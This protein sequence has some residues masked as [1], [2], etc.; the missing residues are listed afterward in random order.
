MMNRSALDALK[1]L[2]DYEKEKEES[3]L[4]KRAQEE[5]RLRLLRDAVLARIRENDAQPLS[6]TNSHGLATREAFFRD[7]HSQSEVIAR[8]LVL[9]AKARTEQITKVLAA[10]R[11]C[12]MVEHLI[13]NLVAA[14]RAAA[15]ATE[16]KRLDD[17][18]QFQHF[19]RKLTLT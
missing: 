1:K 17:F 9:A 4:K 5:S 11:K 8:Q 19:K 15:D 10:K 12:D 7:L 6:A 16:R 13:E 2:R 18:S 3:E 14:E